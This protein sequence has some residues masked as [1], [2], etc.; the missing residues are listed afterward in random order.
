[1]KYKN[2]IFDFDGVL[3][4]S[5]HIKT[6]A[7]YKLY[8]SYGKKIAEKVVKHHQ[9][10]GGM[11]RFEK[12]PFYHKKYLGLITNDDDINALSADFSNIVVQDVV[13]ADEVKGATWFLKKYSNKNKWIVSA[14][15]HEEMIEIIKKRNMSKFFKAVYGS[16]LKK[17]PIV[18][19]IINE[20]L[21]K[22]EDTIFLG[23]ALSDYN[24]AKEN[25]IHFALRRTPENKNLFKEDQNL[26]QF[27]DFYE[28]D[29]KI[30]S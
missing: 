22:I 20:N 16:P 9:E 28:L 29:K 17:T 23:D 5:L 19:K 10:N 27:I 4:E 30:I 12:F 15:P 25:D 26:I 2:I 14:T 24:A 21:L 18:K 7:F 6:Q 8:Q 1:M 13:H 11:S 3:A